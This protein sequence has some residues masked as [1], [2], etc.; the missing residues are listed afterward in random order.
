[1]P[2]GKSHA[3]GVWEVHALGSPKYFLRAEHTFI[4]ISGKYTW[5]QF[6][7]ATWLIS[8]TKATAWNNWPRI[9]WKVYNKINSSPQSS[10]F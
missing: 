10:Y 6:N 7:K 3:R 8:L 1:M 4:L 9:N 5:I 2:K